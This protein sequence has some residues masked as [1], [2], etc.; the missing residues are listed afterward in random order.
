M[1][2]FVTLEETKKEIT[3][4]QNQV[5]IN[6]YVIPLVMI[7]LIVF[8]LQMIFPSITT[9]FALNP[10]EVFQRPWI[11]LTS[12]FLHGGFSHL[13]FNMYALFLFGILLEQ[14]IG[15][16]KFLK[17]YLISGI[18]VS[19]LSSFFY[20][21]LVLGASGAIMAVIGMLIVL[22]PNLQ[23][24]FFFVLPLRL[25]QAGIIWFILDFLG[26]FTNNT[27]ANLGHIF[28]LSIGLGYGYYLLQK[29][30]KFFKKFTK[31]IHLTEKEQKDY[32]KL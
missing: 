7:N 14:K 5:Q 16:K 9:N 6:S 23:L 11:I 29:R 28:G 8:I 26:L 21:N 15:H 27:V 32:K 10:Q 3:K 2:E 19:F 4:N 22:N 25:W 1:A 12:F 30:K 31:S 18:L 13:F 17:F 20:T 24:Y